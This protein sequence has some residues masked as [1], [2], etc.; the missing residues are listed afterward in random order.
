MPRKRNPSH[1]YEPK[2]FNSASE[3][4]SVIASI[5]KETIA[6]DISYRLYCEILLES[7][8]YKNAFL[9]TGMFWGFILDGLLGQAVLTLC[10][11]YDS[12]R[13]D[14]AS[15]ENVLRCL[16]LHNHLGNQNQ[17][18]K[19]IELVKS[20]DPLVKSLRDWR[21]YILAH[22]NRSYATKENEIGNITPHHEHLRDLIDRAKE[23][24]SRYAPAFAESEIDSF[25]PKSDLGFV[26]KSIH[27]HMM[28]VDAPIR[29]RLSEYG[30]N[31]DVFLDADGLEHK[32]A[33]IRAIEPVVETADN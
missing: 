9:R 3:F 11:I 25:V 26:F 2:A 31:P 8:Q 15:L 16:Q 5:T 22:A 13:F 29:T 12:A 24:L 6:A 32:L 20:S 10:R 33:E 1:Y 14:V 23:I 18:C 28:V 4:D 21:N 19:D 30:L 17:L 27:E 7:E